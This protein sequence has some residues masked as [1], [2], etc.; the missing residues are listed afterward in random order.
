MP[1]NSNETK[2]ISALGTGTASSVIGTPIIDH[3]T[4]SAS[5]QEGQS[6]SCSSG[7]ASNCSLTD[8]ILVMLLLR[9]NGESTDYQNLEFRANFDILH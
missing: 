1:Q 8:I 5:L 9:Q 4:V 2:D 6:E 7:C 3:E